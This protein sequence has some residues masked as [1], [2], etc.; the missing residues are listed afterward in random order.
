MIARIALEHALPS[1]WIDTVFEDHRQRQYSREL[2]FS[3]VIELVTLVSLGLRPSLRAAVR[4]LETLPVSLGALYDKGNRTEPAILHAH[5]P[6][7]LAGGAGQLTWGV[8]L[9]TAKSAAHG[10]TSSCSVRTVSRFEPVCV[11]ALPGQ[12]KLTFGRRH[13]SHTTIPHTADWAQAG[14]TILLKAAS[15]PCWRA[16]HPPGS[17]RT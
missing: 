11:L 6:A 1:D 13:G 4:T 3:T 9:S 5:G 7:G 14:E 15:Q 8:L 12:N 17:V 2:L 16:V 10:T